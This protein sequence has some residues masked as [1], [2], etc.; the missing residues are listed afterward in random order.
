MAYNTG[1]WRHLYWDPDIDVIV[2]ASNA[3]HT[4]ALTDALV[5][6][7]LIA[8]G[9]PFVDRTHFVADVT[10]MPDFGAPPATTDV[11]VFGRAVAP[12]TPIQA[13][14][15][16]ADITLALSE[17]A[18]NTNVHRLM[19]KLATNEQLVLAMFTFRSPYPAGKTPETAAPGDTG[20]KLT[21]R[22][23]QGTK[24]GK[25]LVPGGGVGDV[26]SYNLSVA[27]NDQ[28]GPFYVD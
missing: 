18:A 9:K 2:G 3:L 4:A 12:T 10:L 6:S 7:E 27:V 19:Q 16:Q 11:P 13:T 8:S 20:A 17:G 25:G 24:A 15:Q 1:I 28:A 22:L 23:I 14:G 26:E 21:V 5:A